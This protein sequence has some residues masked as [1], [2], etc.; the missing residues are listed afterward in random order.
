MQFSVIL[1]TPYFL[2][3]I[4]S[5]SSKPCQ[6]DEHLFKKQ[7]NLIHII[8][9]KEKSYFI[10]CLR[11]KLCIGLYQAANQENNDDYS[12]SNHMA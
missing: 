10:S 12:L 6:Q 11:Q 8:T 5:V 4:Q 1:K 9:F 2:Q 3:R 7:L